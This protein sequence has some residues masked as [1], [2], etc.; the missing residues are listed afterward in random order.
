MPTTFVNSGENSKHDT[1]LHAF[2]NIANFSG[3]EKECAGD[4]FANI[5]ADAFC[6]I[7]GQE[8]DRVRNESMQQ[9]NEMRK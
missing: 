9:V 2:K 6:E 1:G 4:S 5:K 8:I 3:I 7:L